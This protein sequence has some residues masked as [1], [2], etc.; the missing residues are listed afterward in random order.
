[1]PDRSDKLPAGLRAHLASLFPGARVVRACALGPDAHPPSDET[2]KELGYGHPL[3]VTLAT[4][5]GTTRDVVLHTAGS[6]EYGHDRRA[7]R[8]AAQVLAYDTFGLFP[9]HVRAI[10]VGAL[11]DDG[12]LVSLRA[13][14]EAYLITEWAEGELYADDLRR[15]AR[16]GIVRELDVARADALVRYLVALHRTPGTHEGAYVRAIRDLVGAGEGIAGIVDAYPDDTPGAPRARLDAIERACLEHRLRLRRRTDRLRRTHG[17]FHPFNLLFDGEALTAL[18]ASRGAQGDPADDLA[19]L[20]INHLFFGL[21][22]R[23]VWKD[24][25]GALWSRT[26]DRYLRASG[27]DGV[28]EAIAPFFAWR[29]LVVSSPRWYPHLRGEDRDR[30]LRFVERVLAAPRFDPAIG[31]EAMT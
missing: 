3:R 5:S 14:G 31:I 30:L 10:D 25:L 1:M 28:L 18:D 8:V 23:D 29:A 6:D 27:D 26:F 9:Q 24:G 21:E 12:T 2:E 16:D 4:E 19:S 17:D 7:D 11:R 20:T 15:I 22:H 13:T